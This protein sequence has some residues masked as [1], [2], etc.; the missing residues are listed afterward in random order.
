MLKI[1]AHPDKPFAC[2]GDVLVAALEF[3]HVSVLAL[4][5]SD[6]YLE[7]DSVVLRFCYASPLRARLWLRDDQRQLGARFGTRNMSFAPGLAA[8]GLPSDFH[9]FRE[10][11]NSFEGRID[12]SE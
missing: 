4:G 9:G 12:A 8:I 10:R 6:L 3:E 2:R 7:I 11:K 5:D 1:P